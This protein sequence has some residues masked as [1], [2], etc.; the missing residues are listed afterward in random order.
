MKIALLFL[1][2]AVAAGVAASVAV[3]WELSNS[4]IAGSPVESS[5][6]SLVRADGVAANSVVTDSVVLSS[7]KSSM[8]F[9]RLM[10]LC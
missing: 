6:L 2:L 1:L 4:G 7:S 8:T 10:R 3:V 9:L 5:S